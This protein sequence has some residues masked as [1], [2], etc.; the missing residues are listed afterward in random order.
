MRFLASDMLFFNLAINP[1]AWS[2][3]KIVTYLTAAG[4]WIRAAK[5][6]TY[7][8]SDRYYRAAESVALGEKTGAD[9]FKFVEELW[10]AGLKANQVHYNGR[11]FDSG[12]YFFLTC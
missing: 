10:P 9:I 1:T 5:L 2:V 7:K 8:W 4:D 3:Q 12:N 6:D 11:P